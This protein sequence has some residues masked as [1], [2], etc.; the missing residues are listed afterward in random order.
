MDTRKE[1]YS[2]TNSLVTWMKPD[3]K[4]LCT[5]PSLFSALQK[6][7]DSEILVDPTMMFTISQFPPSPNDQSLFHSIQSYYLS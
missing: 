3:R 2:S 6:T 4:V 1:Q 7:K 5:V